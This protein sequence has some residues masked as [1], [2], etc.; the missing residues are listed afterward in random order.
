MKQ[1][2]E[3]VSSSSSFPSDENLV[4]RFS[5][6]FTEDVITDALSTIVDNEIYSQTLLTDDEKHSRKSKKR[7]TGSVRL[8]NNENNESQSSLFHQ[9]RHRSSS[10]F[11]SITNNNSR[12]ETVDSIVNNIAQQ[13]YVD[14]F[15]ELR[16]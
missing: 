8:I 9:I 16:R 3:D 13:I 12:R 10:A 4:E 6:R 14:S 15:D 7:S 5:N 2:I 1:S 11:R